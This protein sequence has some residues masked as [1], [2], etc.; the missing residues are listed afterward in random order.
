[1]SLLKHTR[2]LFTPD[3]HIRT[4]GNADLHALPRQFDAL[5]W[6]MAKSRSADWQRDFEA[7]VRDRHLMLLQEAAL[8][9]HN[10]DLFDGHD[11]VQ[12][13][14]ARAFAWAKSGIETGVKTGSR[15]GAIETLGMQSEYKEPFLGTPKMVLK[16]H[17]PMQG[18]SSRLMVLNAHGINFSSLRPF[19]AQLRQLVDS[20]GTHSGPIILAGD[21]NTW[22]A[23]RYRE[24]RAGASE[25]GLTDL[26][27]ERSKRWNHMGQHL[28]HLFYRGLDLREAEVIKDIRSSDHYPIV[29]SFSL[30]DAD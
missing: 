2:Q 29:A 25:L 12:W 11:T 22:N 23:A 3:N 19:R 18:T 1:M 13:V 8:S 5:V 24:L 14:M 4:L 7:L 17:Y 21:F 15:V 30:P 16:T 6:N 20:V 26:E 9:K 28:D 10:L 27:L